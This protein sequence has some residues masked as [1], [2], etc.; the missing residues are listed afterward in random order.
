MAANLILTALASICL[1]IWLYLTFAHCGFWKR[2]EFLAPSRANHDKPQHDPSKDNHGQAAIISLSPA[3]NEAEL[4]AQ[5][6]G[7][8][9]G[10]AYTGTFQSLL[11]DDSST[12][13]TAK[14]AH[15]TILAHQRR[16]EVQIHAEIIQAPELASGWSGKLWALQTGLDHVTLKKAS[17]DYYWLSDADIHHEPDVL[18]RLVNHAQTNDLALVSL[19]VV[20]NCNSWWEKRIIPAFIYFFQLLYPFAAINNPRNKIGGAAG[21]CILIRRDALEA[22]GGFHAI[23]DK[24]IDDCELGKAVKSKGYNIW[25]GHGMESTS[26]RESSGLSPLWNMVTRTAFVQLN[27]SYI[28]L[29]FSI[30][31]MALLYICPVFAFIFGSFY[32]ELLLMALGGASWALMAITFWPTLKA[33]KRRWPESFLLP[34]TAIGFRL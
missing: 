30:F 12:D 9:I 32:G 8:V 18:Q 27:H 6:F 5:S 11:I 17:A 25:L 28:Y 14:Y 7:S 2:R 20:L 22:I 31:G 26:L 21:G 13:D 3:R 34:L 16:D 10:Q 4:I 19:M 33:Y 23:K 24:L 1:I 29:F 15:E